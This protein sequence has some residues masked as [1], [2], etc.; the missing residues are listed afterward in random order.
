[1]SMRSSGT[2]WR[3]AVC[4]SWVAFPAVAHDHTPWWAEAAVEDLLLLLGAF[5]G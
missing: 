2:N 5:S 4:V 3:L 1:M